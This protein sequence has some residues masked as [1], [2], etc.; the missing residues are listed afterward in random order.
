MPKPQVPQTL[1]GLAKLLAKHGERAMLV[2]EIDPAMR[3]PASKVVI[4]VSRI[5]GFGNVSN[6]RGK[7][8]FGTGA[9]FGKVFSQISGENGLLKQALSMLANPLV[10]NR[11]TVFEGL[12]SESPFFDLSTAL[13]TLRA[14]IRLQSA[15]TSMI[16]GI[17]EFLVA[18]AEGLNRGEFPAQVEFPVL[19]SNYR[20]GFFRVSPGAGKNT[21]SAS[22]RTKLRRNIVSGPEI[23]VS[24][25]T[26]I[27]VR[28]PA[29]E[30]AL[31]RQ[32]L[33]DANMKVAAEAAA[34]EMIE[35]AD[36]EDDPYERSLIEIA[37]SRA[38]RRVF[39]SP[40]ITA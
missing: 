30:K 24:S 38:L 31:A 40:F 10:R 25:S 6:R 18:A 36:L 28:S 37:V 32:A 35:I 16:L 34:E 20:V 15:T 7:V 11:V 33:S 2:P 14:R 23:V 3:I 9:T 12:D 8:S 13:V 5:P 26:T 4:D 27:P 17:E 22:I 21:V 1:V 39:E 19:D 29:A